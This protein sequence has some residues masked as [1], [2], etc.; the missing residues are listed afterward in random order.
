[1]EVRMLKKLI[2]LSALCFSFSS[3]AGW[4][5]RAVMA[6]I[7]YWPEWDTATSD[8]DGEM[9]VTCSKNVFGLGALV[10]NSGTNGPGDN[11]TTLPQD[12]L[13]LRINNINAEESFN[14][15]VII[16][17]DEDLKHVS[18]EEKIQFYDRLI[19][20][21]ERLEQHRAD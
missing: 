10:E 17:R 21:M 15:K 16:P 2:I 3:H 12:E 5:F 4:K 8:S 18:D 19:E 7:P 20:R 13:V 1:M 9:S 11:L 14:F 6:C